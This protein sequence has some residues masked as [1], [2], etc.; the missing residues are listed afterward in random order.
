MY[1]VQ[2]KQ[3][4]II[5]Y[6]EF[7]WT[8]SENFIQSEPLKLLSKASVVQNQE[9][10]GSKESL[11]YH[12]WWPLKKRTPLNILKILKAGGLDFKLLGLPILNCISFSS[13]IYFFC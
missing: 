4:A 13:L 9:Q 11:Q 1:V 5:V 3:L 7:F 10:S 2:M 12:G 8:E 6:F